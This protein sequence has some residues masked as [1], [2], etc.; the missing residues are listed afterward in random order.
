MH[1]GKQIPAVIEQVADIADDM[2]V[3]AVVCRQEIA[4]LHVVAKPI[5]G[6][7]HHA[8]RFTADQ[9]LHG[10]PSI[11][12][13]SNMLFNV[14]RRLEGLML[15]YEGLTRRLSRE[16]SDV[17]DVTLTFAE[18]EKACGSPLPKNAWLPFFWDNPAN[19]P[20]VSGPKKAVRA[21]GF[22][23]I[24]LPGQGKVLFTRV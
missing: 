3:A 7:A 2:P 19:R 23:A 20:Y 11:F 15:K 5:E 18:I 13:F 21:A 12:A 9:D 17:K 4:G 10:W 8:G 16:R 22:R 14:F 6:A 1:D 24:L